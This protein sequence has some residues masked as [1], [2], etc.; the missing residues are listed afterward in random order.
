MLRAACTVY[1]RSIVL[2]EVGKCVQSDVIMKVYYVAI[3]SMLNEY[4]YICVLLVANS[5]AGQNAASHQILNDKRVCTV[6]ILRLARVGV[7]CQHV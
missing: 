2:N 4:I 5:G 3:D 6:V 1:E 7:R